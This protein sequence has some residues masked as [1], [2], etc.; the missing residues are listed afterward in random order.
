[1]FENYYVHEFSS[2]RVLGMNWYY[3]NYLIGTLLTVFLI[4]K[5]NKKYNLLTP[6]DILLYSFFSVIGYIIGARIFFV[7]V[8]SPAYFLEHAA[9]IPLF[10]RGGMSFH[11]ALIG[12]VVSSFLVAKIKKQDFFNFTDLIATFAPLFLGLGRITNFLNGELVGRVTTVPWAVIFPK[13]FY[14]PRHPSQLY[15]AFFEGVVLFLI[16]F[17]NR[18][19]LSAPGF[20]S[21]SFLILYGGFR[22]GCEFFRRPDPQ[23]GFMFKYFTMGQLLC[24]LM[25]VIGGG[26]YL[27]K[28]KI[29]LDSGSDKITYK[30]VQL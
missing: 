3:F 27:K 23:I 5:A 13:Y 18:K 29:K 28:V 20:Q 19:K 10:W 2:G 30:T 26:V 4:I 15:E 25:I 16:L 12:I 6:Q 7:L 17:F 9:E 24:F 11:G 22:F 8:Y 1:M 14:V 21:M